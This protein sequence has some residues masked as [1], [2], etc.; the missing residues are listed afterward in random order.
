[1]VLL[2][3]REHGSKYDEP[4]LVSIVAVRHVVLKDI[5]ALRY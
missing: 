1:M 4:V 3:D 2:T 5:T